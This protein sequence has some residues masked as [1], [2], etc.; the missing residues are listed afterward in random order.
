MMNGSEIHIPAF[1]G[2]KTMENTPAKTAS[3]RSRFKEYF[4]DDTRGVVADLRA[5][6]IEPET[7]EPKKP[8][9]SV[10]ARFARALVK[11]A[12]RIA[13]KED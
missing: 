9:A 5:Y 11:A 2:G 13:P 4:D 10:R 1:T 8:S 7:P 12:N 6:F 3:L